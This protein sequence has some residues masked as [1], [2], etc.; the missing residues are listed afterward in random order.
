MIVRNDPQVRFDEMI[1]RLHECDFRL[2]AQRMELV[3]LVASSEDHPNAIQLYNK[4]SE[5]FPTMSLATVYKTLALLKKEDQVLEI[6]L[7]DES[8]YDGNR[9]DPHPHLV[10]TNC[11][12]IV[13]G[14]FN[15][16]QEAIQH[17]EVASGYQIHHPKV[18]FFGVCP[19]CQEKA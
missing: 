16:P 13:D 9:P 14:D 12:R 10:C 8:H 18:I 17:L 6:D 1:A 15:L 19:E 7:H 4:V 3:R 5:R 2:T 11:N